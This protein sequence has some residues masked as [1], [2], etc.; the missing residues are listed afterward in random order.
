MKKIIVTGGQGFIGS[1]LV[2][3]LLNKNY[4]VI[5]IDKSSYSA[6]PYNVRNFK[7]NK[8]YTFFK[9]DINN[10]N[11]IFKILKKFKP[12]GIFN[13]AAETHVD[14]SID[15]PQAFLKTNI[16]GVFNLLESIKLFKKKFKK[17]IKL[18]HV[19]TDEVYGDI[20]KSTQVNENYNYNPSSPYS[21]SKA[22]ADQL[23]KSYFRT[24][25]SQVVI[26]NACNN[27]GPNQLPEKFIPKVI[28]N[29]LNNKPIP[30]YGKGRNVREW[31]YVKDNCEALL[32]IFLRGK[33]GKNYNIGTGIRV[34]NIELIRNILNIAKKNKIVLGRRNK[35]KFVK[36]RPGHDKRYAINSTRIKRE[37]NWRY[38]TSLS[39]GLNKT[40]NW[41][42]NNKKFFKLISKKNINKRFGLKI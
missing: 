7:K 25:G 13:L 8:N 2:E 34:K 6:N 29:I 41:Y 42:M 35:I 27:Y 18:V 39:Q 10:K 21:A 1:N 33:I 9:V 15:N 37:L 40:F 38:K 17:K 20:R 32:K 26:A 14:R 16:F 4:F 19:S 3:F 28:F 23:I 5:N 30:L 12:V 24:Y 11:K 36:D 31:I 22:A